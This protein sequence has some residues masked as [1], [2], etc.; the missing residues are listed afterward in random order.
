MTILSH[1]QESETCPDERNLTNNNTSEAIQ[2][3]AGTSNRQA[4]VTLHAHY[5][6]CASSSKCSISN[7]FDTSRLNIWETSVKHVAAITGGI[8]L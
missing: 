4:V 8:Y 6:A 1:S 2:Q 7:V 3:A 5:Q